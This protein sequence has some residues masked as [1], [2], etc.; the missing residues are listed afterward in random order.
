MERSTNDGE[1]Q[2]GSRSTAAASRQS[3]WHPV[4]AATEQDCPADK[5]LPGAGEALSE[6]AAHPAWPTPLSG[7]GGEMTRRLSDLGTLLV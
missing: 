5:G 7:E 2:T 4:S 3:P 6:K 1:L